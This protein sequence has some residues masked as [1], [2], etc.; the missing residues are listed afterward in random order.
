MV[1]HP[2]AMGAIVLFEGCGGPL[3]ATVTTGASQADGVPACRLVTPTPAISRRL[4]YAVDH[5]EPSR[6]G[7]VTFELLGAC[8][9]R[10]YALADAS[11]APGTDIG[12]SLR[13]QDGP[14]IFEG[15]ALQHWRLV[16]DTGG[17][18]PPCGQSADSFPEQLVRLAGLPCYR[19]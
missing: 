18:L 1:Q 10:S 4:A 13:F 8:G 19:P 3:A 11:L 5:G 15:S 7:K 6:A 14:W 2:G 16:G 12:G 17:G 9:T